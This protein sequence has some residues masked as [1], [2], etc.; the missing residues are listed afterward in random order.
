MRNRFDQLGK[1]LG[2]R[3]L[4]P[5]GVR[6]RTTA[7]H[8]L[9]AE[10]LYA[11]LRHEPDPAFAAE[12]AELGLLGELTSHDCLLE[13]HSEPPGPDELRACLAKQLTYWHQRT[14]DAR[15]TGTRPA[16]PHLWLIS[17][18]TPRRLLAELPFHPTRRG[19]YRFGG[20]ILRLGLVV[21]T[22]LPTNRS[23]LLVRL[24]AG[25]PLLLR[26]VHEVATLSTVD[27]VRR[28]AEPIL[29][30]FARTFHNVAP[31]ELDAGEQEVMMK[32]YN[33]F[34]EMRED[35]RAEGRM[36]GRREMLRRQL[37]LKFGE[38]SA[39]VEQRLASASPEDLERFSER[40][41]FADSIVA[42]F[43]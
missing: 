28:L 29:L 24:M 10:T 42:V 40:I 27:P 12:R 14:R 31:T 1:E 5:L 8:A 13:L 19:I 26:A 34:D 23:T 9:N 17:A 16:P 20:D 6:D 38:L 11:D 35:G 22:E 41:L 37:C 43:A 39:E 33:S 30:Q 32:L 15:S 21:A 25:G 18:G 4:E 7:Q 3:A 36:E 2:L